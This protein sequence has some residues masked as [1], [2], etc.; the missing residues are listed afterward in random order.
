M[1]L[2]NKQ[3]RK[4]K[5]FEINRPHNAGRLYNFFISFKFR[6]TIELLPFPIKGLSVLDIC[7]GS[8][9]ISEYY[10]KEGTVVTGTDISPECIERARVRAQRYGFSS[11]FQVA[12]SENL[13]FPDNS[14]D[15]V[16]VHDGLH[17]LAKP[18]KAVKEMGRVARKGIIIIE[19]AKTLMTEFSILL[20]ISLRYEG[21]DF[22]YRFR[23]DEFI[24]WLKESG[25]RKA[26]IKRYIMYYSHK[27]GR[28][29]RIFDFPPLFLLAKI[30][31]Y[32]IN[33]FLGRFG[34]KIQVIGLK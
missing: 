5:E 34:N 22:V 30:V 28:L 23:K 10:T 21:P 32:L 15:I 3:E 31:F 4:N 20:G 24:S 19:P 6:E 25:I 17:H 14:F 1:Q 29:F 33:I 13:P 2:R 7:C 27:P 16:S 12:D 11:K 8:G 18:W 9:M 26:I